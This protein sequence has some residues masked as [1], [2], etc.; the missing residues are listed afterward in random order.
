[1]TAWFP[2]VS[3]YQGSVDWAKIKANGAVGGVCKATQG[4]S[5]L[6]GYLPSNRARMRAAKIGVRGFYHFG[7]ILADPVKQARWFTSKVGPLLPGEFLVLDIE[8]GTTGSMSR[9]RAW[10]QAFVD[11]VYRISGLWCLIYTGP[12]Y[13]TAAFGAWKPVN[14]LLWVAHYTS[15]DRPRMPSGWTAAALWQYT[16]SAIIPGISTRADNSRVLGSLAPILKPFPPV[17]I[18]PDPTYP[19]DTVVLITR[20]AHGWKYL[21]SGGKIVGLTAATVASMQN[22]TGLITLDC[23]EDQWARFVKAYGQPVV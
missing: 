2:D 11:E 23:A 3:H 16:S 21:L 6:D 15:A 14:C 12:A 4:T 19:E 13:W 18:P 9:N 20:T 5:G 1:M 22:D 7:N 8:R 17:V 10:V